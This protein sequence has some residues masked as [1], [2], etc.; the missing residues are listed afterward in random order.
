MSVPSFWV[1]FTCNDK[2]L[3]CCIQVIDGVMPTD[4]Q[5]LKH[6]SILM[7]ERCSP[8]TVESLRSVQN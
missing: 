3:L 5:F 7:N 6:F 8:L 4:R 2:Q 1:K